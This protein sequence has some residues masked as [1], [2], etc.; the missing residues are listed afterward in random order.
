MDEPKHLCWKCAN[1]VP[2]RNKFGRYTK[3]CN[4]SI[5]LAPVKGWKT[6]QKHIITA[7]PRSYFNVVSCPKF[8]EG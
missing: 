4:W 8:K 3:G 6:E 7:D 2:C 1:A 5:Y